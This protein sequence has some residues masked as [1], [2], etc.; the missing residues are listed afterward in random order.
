M[1]TTIMQSATRSGKCTLPRRA[2]AGPR[3][4]AA[5]AVPERSSSVK[6]GPRKILEAG[7][8]FAGA[9]ALAVV[10]VRFL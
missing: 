8:K 3:G 10:L 5:R 7:S 6:A 1:P 9:C 4:V 2:V